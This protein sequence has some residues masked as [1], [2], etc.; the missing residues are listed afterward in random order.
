LLTVLEGHLYEKDSHS[1][2]I[3]ISETSF[4]TEEVSLVLIAWIKAK[5][6]GD[7]D[8]FDAVDVFLLVGVE[9]D[10][11]ILLRNKKKPE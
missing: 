7:L 8:F 4:F 3:G 9:V 10:C 2:D 11:I 5:N 6:L 1:S